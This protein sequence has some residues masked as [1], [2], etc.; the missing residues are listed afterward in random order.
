VGPVGG[1][2]QASTTLARRLGVGD[3]VVLG[4]GAMIGTG[5]FVVFAPAAAA[6]GAGLL[7]GLAVAAVVA[8]ANA[9]SSARLAALYP[10]SGGTYV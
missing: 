7:L 10:A 9:T 6:T 3:A 8:Y 4:L 5:V 2:A 1:A